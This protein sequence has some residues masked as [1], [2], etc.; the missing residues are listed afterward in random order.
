MTPVV[1][2]LIARASVQ[3]GAR[4]TQTLH[5]LRSQRC[6]FP[7]EIVVIDRV[8]DVAAQ[9]HAD[10]GV[11]LR[12]QHVAH[13]TPLPRMR[14]IALQMARGRLVAV[15]EDHCIAEPDWLQQLHD[16]FQR[17]RA[18]VAIGGGV[19]NG[20]TRSAW[21]WA[22][23][24]CEYAAFAPP[25]RADEAPVGVNIA[26]VRDALVALSPQAL[27]D[28]FWE[29]TAHPLLQRAGAK[30]ASGSRACV[31]HSKHFGFAGFVQQRY[32]YSRH[33]AGARF[34]RILPRAGAA[35][36]SPLLPLL[37]AVRLCRVVWRKPALRRASVRAAPYLLLLHLVWAWGEL[38]GYALGPADALQRIE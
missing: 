27:T 26:Y 23:Y 25:L 30:V 10:A 12:C 24:L 22:T 35:L 5:S 19:V 2:V 33:Y 21:D 7:F 20:L 36:A 16:E 17:D 28:G 8:G 6:N 3:D 4:F 9:P 32:L 1:S 11:P 29:T 15:T 18:L 13:D 31:V 37:L 14:F 38:I 34:S